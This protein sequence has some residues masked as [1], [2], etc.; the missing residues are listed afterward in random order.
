MSSLSVDSGAALPEN[1]EHLRFTDPAWQEDCD[2][3]VQVAARFAI[4]RAV[5]SLMALRL[6]ER[7]S[8]DGLRVGVQST[9]ATDPAGSN[10]FDLYDIL[11][12]SVVGAGRT[13]RLR[14]DNLSRTLWQ[15]MAD[16]IYDQLG[17][18]IEPELFS[19]MLFVAYGGELSHPHL[20]PIIRDLLR[21]FRHTDAGGLY[22]FFVSLRFA[23]DI[24]CTAVACRARL[25]TCDIDPVTMSGR[26]VLGKIV[27]RILHSAAVTNVS[28]EANRSAGKNN[29][30]LHAG[31]FKVYPDDHAISGAE[32]DRGLKNNPVV[33]ANALHP[34][35]TA[36]AHG[37]FAPDDAI[38]LREFP[39]GSAKP[40]EGTMSVG[41]IVAANLRY[42]DNH[43]R[44]GAW[45][46]GCRYYTTAEVFLAFYAETLA[47]HPWA[48]AGRET[49]VLLR[50]SV[51]RLVCESPPQTSLSMALLLLAANDLGLPVSGRLAAQLTRRQTHEG[52]WTDFAPLYKLGTA[53]PVYFGSSAL[54]TLLATVALA[55][56]V[57]SRSPSSD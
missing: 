17:F 43:L 10:R 40:R 41:E 12:G 1:P 38:E 24:D 36:L 29:G 11:D 5:Q 8:G 30:P 49:E 37:V 13:G 48:F 27:R 56:W 6:T 23:G 47:A 16:E 52:G 14:A 19:N 26:A 33:A 51:T 42:A 4:E 18:P 50:E 15:E 55:R 39:A 46:E 35:L 44:S 20:S 2:Q 3:G 7:R 57:E 53:R 21:T 22:H 31:V 45:R 25:V 32:L 34:V 54:T 9:L 28:A